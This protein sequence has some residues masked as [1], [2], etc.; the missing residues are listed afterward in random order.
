[1][2][3]STQGIETAAASSGASLRRALSYR[4]LIFYGLAYIAPM[5]PIATVGFVWTEANGL[6]ALAYALGGVCM[7]FTARS[8][9]TMTD[10][11][12][13]AGSVY[14]FARFAL[15]PFA[16]FIAGWMI[17]LD[18]LLVPALVYVVV[19]VALETLIPGVPRAVWIVGFTAI[20][21]AV[22]WFGVTVTS[23]VN[24]ATV[25]IQFLVMVAFLALCT[26]ALYGG[27]GTGSLTLAP[28][29]TASA[30][31]VHKVLAG[32]SIC[33]LAFLGFDAIS[34]LSEE[35]MERD[36]HRVGSSIVAVLVISAVF[37]AISAWIIGN[38]MPGVTSQDPAAAAYDLAAGAIGPWAAVVLAWSVALVVGLTNAIPMQV[39]V[40]R[41]LFAMGRDRQLPAILSRLHPVHNT[42][43]VSM[44][45]TTSITLL[46][47]LLMQQRIDELTSIVN[48]G[49]LCGFLLLH[50]SV[51]AYFGIGRRSRAWFLHW[52]VPICGIVV[53]G[54]VLSGMSE[55]ALEV[56][57][58]WLAIGVAYGIALAIRGR[59]ALTI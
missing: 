51:V 2:T 17:L 49:A 29:F 35:V 36:R 37:F 56:G 32:T 45:V 44:I 10:A 53:V 21:F 6:I 38:L 43:H 1:M 3:E 27:K 5:G 42:P 9:A 19:A 12:P 15:G 58:A 4:D 26:V 59:A 46:V 54:A 7:Y 33:V 23:R 50:V 40:A 55:L 14:G 22:N 28:F 34:T 31:D 11:V 48:F 25:V 47:A 18:Y 30:F 20:T 24:L 8:Y 52:V 57:M 41:V 13:T 16:G 39:G